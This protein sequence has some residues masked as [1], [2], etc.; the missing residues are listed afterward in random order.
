VGIVRSHPVDATDLLERDDL[1]EKLDDALAD[2]GDG[3]GRLCLVAGEA[4]VGK[5]ALTRRFCEMRAG[6]A[7]ILRGACDA[8]FAPRPLGPLLDFAPGAGG[9]LEKLVEAG[10]R[11][12]DVAAALVD[13]LRAHAPTIV[14]IEDLHWA[15]EATLDVLRLLA[16]RIEAIPALVLA[17]YADELS[18][19]HPLR[20]V[21][22]ELAT[23]RALERMTVE[24]LSPAA[25]AELAEP[26]GV[27][28]DELYR[29]TAGNPFFVTE[30]LACADGEIPHTVRDAVLARLARLN[31]E[32]GSLLEAV[33]I[34]PRPAEL[35]LLESLAA[36]SLDALEECVAS[37]MLTSDSGH[38]AFRHELARLTLEE[39][40]APS[41]RVEL[42][43][44]A[45]ATLESRMVGAPV[46]PRLAHHAEAA[47]DAEAVLR[48]APAAAE[49]AAALGAHREAA[50]QYARALR[51]AEGLPLRRRA[52]LLHRRSYETYLIDQYDDS[53]GAM[54]AALA[55]YRTLGDGLG[56]GKSLRSLSH[57][58][59]CPGR[60]AEAR[61]AGN[62]AV[63]V[64]ERLPPGPELAMAYASL[65]ELCTS[66][67]DAEGALSWATRALELAES[68]DNTEIVARALSYIGAI[69]FLG[70]SQE[71]KAKLER[72][73]ELA[74]AAGREERV[75]SALLYLA[76]VAC[77]R[78]SYAIANRYLD[79]G[80]RYCA[81]RGQDLHAFYFRAYRARA[82]LD[83]G[84]WSEA[85]GLAANV[86]S[87][88]RTSVLPRII[89]LAVI[90]LLC[91]RRGDAGTWGALDEALALAEPSDE[92]PRI[93]LVAAARSEAAWL[94]G[95]L[96]TIVP[97]TENALVLARRRRSRW[98]LDLAY[99]RWRAGAQEETPFDASEPR[100]LEIAG[101]AKRAAEAWSRLGCP[102]EAALALADAD[103]ERSLRR[104]LEELEGLGARPAA[105]MVARRLRERGIRG[106]PRGPRPTTRD[107]PAQL[108]SREVEVL[109]LVEEGLRNTDIAKRLFL[110]RRTVD[111]H[112]S[113]ILAK[114]GVRTRG[115]AGA[116]A[117]RA[118][119]IQNR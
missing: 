46:Y 29:K 17:T 7:R 63:T 113:A 118:G 48:F 65:A 77:E 104:S 64:L 105:T 67:D 30:V 87:E 73:V 26:Y 90:G 79:E 95:R 4:G 68:L 60:I 53:I 74:T 5:T 38:V 37:G 2:A 75:A 100:A 9:D 89:G 111:H 19:S 110:S 102:Y 92:L 31:D 13:E 41:R 94:E 3:R 86:L 12:H 88:E 81:D 28:A 59:W 14:V 93:A 76:V 50:A 55:C 82:E 117:R 97:E 106:L 35:W 44:K 51:F 114:L 45:L 25:V 52:E 80:F 27:D 69:E 70:G 1:L 119:L 101:H 103:D 22:G 20:I 83:Q 33:S 62:D 99:W 11:P 23:E 109:A 66:D 16:R 8:L 47:G 112:V 6:S 24:R 58:L 40:L 57:L 61:D 72:S 85:A 71:G 42:H 54:E 21:L 32:A 18:R 15:D 39:S 98:A 84:N 115:Q 49:R 43:R 108:T 34:I 78:R 10:A 116:A 91:A 56:E 36:D 96:E 107:N